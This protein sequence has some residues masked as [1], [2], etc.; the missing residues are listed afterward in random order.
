MLSIVMCA[1]S[2]QVIIESAERL[3][4][5]IRYFQREHNDSSTGALPDIDMTPFSIVAMAISIG[6]NSPSYGKGRLPIDLIA[7]S[8]AVLFIFSYRNTHPTVSVLSADNRNDVI[9]GIVVLTCGLIGIVD[10]N[11][12]E[13]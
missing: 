6:N 4:K 9:T 1:A 12:I 5:D 3:S 7:G 10:P 8:K 11:R 2:V 13:R